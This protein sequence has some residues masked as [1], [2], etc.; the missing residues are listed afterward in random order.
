MSKYNQLGKVQHWIDH[1]AEC[2]VMDAHE[3]IDED[4]G[5]CVSVSLTVGDGDRYTTVYLNINS[6]PNYIHLQRLHGALREMV[7]VVEMALD[8]AWDR[9]GE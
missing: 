9:F 7:A 5:R 8:A 4:D 6:H 2:V 1:S 3:Y